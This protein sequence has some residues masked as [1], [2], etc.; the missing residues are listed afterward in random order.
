[1]GDPFLGRFRVKAWLLQY[2]ERLVPASRAQ[3]ANLMLKIIPEYVLRKGL[4]E[5]AIRQA[6]LKDYSG[7]D[8]LLGLLQTPFDEQPAH[9]APYA[10]ILPDWAVQIEISC[11]S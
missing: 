2:S 4:G 5:L 7:V 10:G 8:T 1:M 3:A 6:K 9:E 11:S